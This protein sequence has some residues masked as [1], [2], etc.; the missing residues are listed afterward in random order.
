MNLYF[1][2]LWWQTV[3]L[4]RNNIISISIGVTIVYGVVLFLFRDFQYINELLVFVIM[5]DPAIIGYFFI[6]LSLYIEYRNQIWSAL[7]V[8]PMEL[9]MIITAR[10]LVLSFLGIFLSVLLVWIVNGF[11]INY[12]LLF[13]GVFGVTILSAL[14]A[15]LL[16][17]FSDDFMKF[18]IRSI[19]IF[20]PF[21]SIP[22]LEYLGLLD[23]G[24]IHYIFPIQVC[25]DMI[26]GAMN[27]NETGTYL[28]HIIG[29]FGWIVSLY[30]LTRKMFYKKMMYT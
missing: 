12:L 27:Q 23:F 5:N 6:A 4:N 2:Q 26:E 8:T 18:A 29:M 17:P 20:L 9:F 3:I 10:L 14:L 25:V 11:D 22:L 21:V 1:K 16:V 15:V 13:L 19:P 24:A 30:Y 28:L 7:A